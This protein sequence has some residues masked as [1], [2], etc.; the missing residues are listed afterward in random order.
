M[1]DSPTR[2]QIERTF[3]RIL[4]PDP[5]QRQRIAKVNAEAEWR[6]RCWNCKAYSVTRLPTTEPCPHCGANRTS[7]RED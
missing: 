1:T 6:I 7:R 3:K 2:E 5:A 4:G